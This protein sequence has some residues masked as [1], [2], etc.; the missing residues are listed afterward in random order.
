VDWQLTRAERIAV[1]KSGRGRWELNSTLAGI[2]VR[3]M[4]PTELCTWTNTS[5]LSHYTWKERNG[6]WEECR[7]S[8]PE[9]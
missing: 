1:G 5:S 4:Y 3:G 9:N 2:G 8:F 7:H 6:K